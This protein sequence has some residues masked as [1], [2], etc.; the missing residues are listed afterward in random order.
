MNIDIQDQG[1]A[2]KINGLYSI[3]ASLFEEDN[4]ISISLDQFDME[5]DHITNNIVFT[6]RDSNE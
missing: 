3:D 4:E 5:Y 6:L 2:V 1:F